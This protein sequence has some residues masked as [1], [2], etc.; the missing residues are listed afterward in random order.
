MGTIEGL[1]AVVPSA[2]QRR[3]H[4]RR[5]LCFRVA[6]NVLPDSDAHHLLETVLPPDARPAAE[7]GEL[8]TENVSLGGLCLRAWAGPDR[9]EAVRE[10]DLLRIEI[11]PP[12]V[13]ARVRCLGRVAWVEQDRPTGSLRAGVTFVAVNPRDLEGLITPEGGAPDSPGRAR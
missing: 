13:E 2:R 6:F 8:Y 11:H 5:D 4:R 12:R 9:A 10:G 3:R 1:A 7:D